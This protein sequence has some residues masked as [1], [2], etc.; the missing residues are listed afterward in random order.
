MVFQDYA[1]Y[2]QMRVYD[3]LA[4]GLRRRG[5]AREEIERRVRRASA[6]LELDPLLGRRPRELSGGQRAARGAGPRAGARPGGAA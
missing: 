3:N 1:L 5:L 4:F 6:A 2:P